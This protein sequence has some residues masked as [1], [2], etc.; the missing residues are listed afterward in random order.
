LEYYGILK[1]KQY[2][3][4]SYWLGASPA[5]LQTNNAVVNGVSVNLLP[6]LLINTNASTVV[7]PVTNT[8]AYTSTDTLPIGTYL[9]TCEVYVTP[10]TGGTGWIATD[11]LGWSVGATTGATDNVSQLFLPFYMAGQSGYCNFNL[12]GLCIFSVASTI[13][14]FPTYNI[15]NTGAKYAINSFTYQKVA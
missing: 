1:N 12:V 13:R 14:V 7:L 11:A 4:M 2:I 15:T 6:V 8:A 9:I 3:E 5:V 10:P